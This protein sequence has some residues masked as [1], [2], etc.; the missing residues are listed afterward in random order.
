MQQ[1]E[2]IK[3]LKRR[4][5]RVD[6]VEM[7]LAQLFTQQKALVFVPRQNAE[8]AFTGIMGSKGKTREVLAKLAEIRKKQKS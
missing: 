4:L 8:E 7:Q 1:G 2:E 3:D 6:R 5:E